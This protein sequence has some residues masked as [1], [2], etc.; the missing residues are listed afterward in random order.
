MP[1]YSIRPVSV[2][3][4][5][6]GKDY[7]IKDLGGSMAGYTELVSK[8]LGVSLDAGSPNTRYT[9]LHELSHVQ[10]DLWTPRTIAK[11]VKKRL[12][13]TLSP[14]AILAASDARI[15]ELLLRKVPDCRDGYVPGPPERLNV[16]IAGYVST[17][18]GVCRDAIGD[19]LE[20]RGMLSPELRARI[21]AEEAKLSSLSESELTVWNVTVPLARKVMAWTEEAE[22]KETGSGG[23][24]KSDTSSSSESE[25]SDTSGGTPDDSQESPDEHESDGSETAD[26]EPESEDSEESDNEA[27][28]DDG[29]AGDE[30]AS[31]E[32]ESDEEIF[33]EPDMDE[34][35]CSHAHGN[36][37]GRTD[38][39]WI[40]PEVVEP[41]LT[42]RQVAGNRAVTS[43]D[44]GTSIRWSNL[45]RISTDGRVFA[46]KT[47]RP[48]TLQK[49]TVLIDVSGSMNI[50]TA[51]IAA[52]VERLPQATIAIYSGD[53]KRAWIVVVA[54]NGRRVADI[55]GPDVPRNGGNTCDGPALLWLSRQDSPRIWICDGFV[56]G[57]GDNFID[58]AECAAIMQAGQIL[59]VS[60]SG[61]IRR[62][63]VGAAEYPNIP[64]VID[65]IGRIERRKF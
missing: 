28:S 63:L 24:E 30:D 46:R 14:A 52:L 9:Q 1:K 13:V 11:K 43:A 50:E 53:G 45:H 27:G 25:K 44:S 38:I 35:E 4:L 22:S 48:G 56:T 60:P 34:S 26:D 40:I 23:S 3:A 10:H 62:E 65:A 16:S 12:G 6:R 8:E 55:D 17:H 57:R 64:G 15:N 42:V 32:A 2:G 7:S 61:K 39:P 29:D 31:S 19:E 33:G 59:Q 41:E 49:G 20:R 36:G 47:R 58:P 5:A 18:A 37:D 54:K 21:D 51:D